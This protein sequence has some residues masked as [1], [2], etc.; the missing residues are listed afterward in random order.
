MVV[1][2]KNEVKAEIILYFR[3]ISWFSIQNF[4]LVMLLKKRVSICKLTSV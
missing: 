3:T 4:A 2:V 1:C